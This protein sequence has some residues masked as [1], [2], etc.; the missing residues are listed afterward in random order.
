MRR[1]LLALLLMLA[2]AGVGRAESLKLSVVTYNIRYDNRGDGEDR[3]EKRRDE[4]A[5]LLRDHDPDV[6]GLQ[7]ALRNQLD[8]LAKGLPGYGEIGVGRDDGK[9]KGEYAAILYRKERF[10]VMDSG[11]FWLSD[12]P[13]VA[14][15]KS[16]GNNVVRICTWARLEDTSGER[17]TVFNVH[18]DH[19]SQPSRERSGA[20]LAERVR[21]VD[22]TVIVTGDFNAGESNPAVQRMRDAGLVDS[23]RVVRADEGEPATFNGFGRAKGSS[24]KI[25]YIWVQRSAKVSDAGIDRREK[26]GRF[27]SDHFAVW[28][29]IEVPPKGEP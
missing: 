24:E 27:P 26:D 20:L 21:R 13:E 11:T 16:W 14:G 25:D 5:R 28:A 8:D 9:H 23:F 6:V 19:E 17:F 3:W 29:K 4:V 22:G 1:I 12:T 18:L 10:K 7:E 2:A 15:S